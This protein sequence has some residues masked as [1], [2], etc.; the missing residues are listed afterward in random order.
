MPE[1]GK[2]EN[3]FFVSEI[4]SINTEDKTVEATVSDETIDRYGEVILATSWKKRLQNYLKHGPLLSSHN[5]GKLTNQIGQVE[6]LKV[7]DGALVAKFKYFAGEGNEEADWAWKLVSKFGVGAYSV[8]FIPFD[9]ETQEYTEDVKKGKKP[10]RVYKDVELVE[11]SQ[12]TVP[13]N[14]SAL[15]RSLE[16]PEVD[17]ATK[18]F[19]KRTMDDI[20]QK[21]DAEEKAKSS[22]KCPKCG[23]KNCA[24]DCQCNDCGNEW[25]MG[26]AADSIGALKDI[27]VLTEEEIK[28]LFNLDDDFDANEIFFEDEVTEKDLEGSLETKPQPIKGDYYHVPAPGQEGKHS[29]HKIRTIAISAKKGIKGHYCIQD[30][31]LT[32]YLFDKKKWTLDEAKAWVKAHSKGLEMEDINMD[33]LMKAIDGMLK[34]YFADFKKEVEVKMD[35]LEARVAEILDVSTEKEVQKTEEEKAVK[36]AEEKAVQE[37]KE[38]EEKEAT[39]YILKVLSESN[40]RL[41]GTVS[42]QS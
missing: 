25:A 17:D 8:G 38:K 42:A 35:G 24:A 31:T 26:T 36:E 11:I 9:W 16:D 2:K 5:Y 7:K 29:G 10:S 14:P 41:K 28:E 3:K 34:T 40:D 39:E 15:Q 21:M 13:A 22:I 32:G 1:Q 20:V 19:Y 4:R 33:E 27:L 12:V 30:K 37:A 23:S 6:T 18:E